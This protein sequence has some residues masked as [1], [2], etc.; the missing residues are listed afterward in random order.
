MKPKTQ[1]VQMS[2]FNAWLQDFIAIDELRK[3]THNEFIA[4]DYEPEAAIRVFAGI[5]EIYRI[6]RPLILD[7]AIKKRYDDLALEIRQDGLRVYKDVM[8][9]RKNNPY[10]TVE[11]NETI[12]NRFDDYF[13]DIYTLRHELGLGIKKIDTPPSDEV[14]KKKLLQV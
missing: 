13:H 14:I 6:I 1:T 7:D 5:N 10:A 12:W 4:L 2:K 3:A 9:R 11:I 8:N